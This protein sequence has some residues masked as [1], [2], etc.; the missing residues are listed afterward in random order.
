MR[1]NKSTDKRM[2][3]E[4]DG[5]AKTLHEGVKGYTQH[6]F[7]LGD[8]LR[9]HP[10]KP[11]YEQEAN[12]TRAKVNAPNPTDTSTP[13][14]TLNQRPTLLELKEAIAELPPDKSAG[15]DG[16]TNRMLQSA[17]TNF[18]HLMFLYISIIWETETYPVEW[19]LALLQAVN[20]G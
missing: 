19:T 5:P 12:L 6:R 3:E 8:E 16:I 4:S 11:W 15:H 10:I 18:L 17:D 20:E 9:E 1:T 13:D 7:A 14:A 2:W